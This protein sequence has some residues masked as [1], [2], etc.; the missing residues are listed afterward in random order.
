M[1]GMADA[2][3]LAHFRRDLLRWYDS[4][5]RDLPWRGGGRTPWR[6]F[7]SEAML[8]QTQVKTVLPYFLRFTERFPTPISLA[9]ADEEEVL[10]LWQGLGYYSRA[11]NL[12]RA[13]R[14]MVERHGGAV[15]ET[16][17][18]L[19]ALPGVGRYT[20]GAVASIAF[21]VPAPILDG[22]VTRVLCRLDLIEGDPRAA[23]NQRRLWERA[24]EVVDPDR[25]GDFNSAVMELGATACTPRSPQCLICP[26]SAYCKARAA[27]VQDRVPPPKKAKATPVVERAAYRVTNAAGG[28][29]VERRPATG[30]W[31]GLWQFVTRPPPGATEPRP[32]G[33]VRHALTHRRYAF[34]CL[35][36]EYDGPPPPGTRWASPAELDALP[37]GRPQQRL[38]ELPPTP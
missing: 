12:Q 35:D 33:E 11:R 28:V 9:Q 30:R 14:A 23:A 10:R 21:G 15:P 25:P 26:V 18:E 38:R 32:A 7:V 17:G 6:V 3:E 8:Q 16:I 22:N 19:I 27:G 36:C 24:A 4:A 13:A 34:R 1:P 5:A 37:M 31:A 20:A 2:A 29:L